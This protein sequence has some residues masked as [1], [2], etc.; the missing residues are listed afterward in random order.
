MA[1]QW[2]LAVLSASTSRRDRTVK[3]EIYRQLGVRE[4]SLYD[5]PGQWLPGAGSC[6]QAEQLQRGRYIPASLA[7]SGW[8]RSEVLGLAVQGAG[9]GVRF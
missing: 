5:P 9:W 4:Y 2:V 7:T 8:P 3:R 1:S 6:L